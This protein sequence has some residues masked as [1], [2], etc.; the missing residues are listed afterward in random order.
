V[1]TWGLGE[2]SGGAVRGRA[3]RAEA[4]LGRPQRSRGSAPHESAVPPCSVMAYS[5]LGM[6]RLTG[7]YS[8]AN[9]PKV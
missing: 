7:K 9:Q 5:P 8:A 6:G 1:P 2:R 3:G 4:G